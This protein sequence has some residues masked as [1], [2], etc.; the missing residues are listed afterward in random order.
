MM[1]IWDDDYSAAP[2]AQR[3][4]R[5]STRS[6]AVAEL[7]SALAVDSRTAH[8]HIQVRR[9]P[10]FDQAASMFF[11]ATW[12][13]TGM[14]ALVK[15]NV[16]PWEL[17]W[18]RSLG[19]RTPD[20]VPQVLTGGERLG[21]YEVRWLALERVPHRLSH[22]WGDRLFDLLAGAAVRFQEAARLLDHRYIGIVCPHY[23]ADTIRQGQRE[24]CPGPVDKVL[25]RLE[26]DWA[27][28]VSVCGLEVCFGDL[29][30]GNALCR[31]DPPGGAGALLI[32]PI[33]RIAPWA[34]DGAYCQVICADS[35]ARMIHRMARRRHERGLHTP[36]GGDLDRASAI[37]LAWLGA[38]WWGI[39]PWRRENS[40]WG[41]Q[42]RRYIEAAAS[43]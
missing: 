15:L 16:S 2:W 29:T 30:T 25:A 43:V 21:R 27:W 18:M 34:W 14:P 39:A 35:D 40:A 10:A 1:D 5:L 3:D 12:A 36:E 28:L 4:R 19:E 20:L 6:E 7:I 23:T 41:A 22:A 31:D 24:G 13:E 37:L 11:S 17:H 8:R 9:E 32:D 26:V 33:P 38:L 42:I